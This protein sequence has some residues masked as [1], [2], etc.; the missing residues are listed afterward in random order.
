MAFKYL[1]EGPKGQT[2]KDKHQAGK[3][4]NLAKGSY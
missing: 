4:F 1:Q 2:G 3:I